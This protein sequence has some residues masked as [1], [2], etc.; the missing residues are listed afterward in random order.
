MTDDEITDVSAWLMSAE[1][2]ESGAALSGCEYCGADAGR[3]AG[4][5]VEALRNVYASRSNYG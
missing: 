4:I 1:A 5:Y 3:E 2:G